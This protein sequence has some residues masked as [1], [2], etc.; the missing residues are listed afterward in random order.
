MTDANYAGT[1]SGTFTIGKATASVTFGNLTQ[2]F[3]GGALSPTVTTT[4]VG[5]AFTLSGAPDT[6]AG[7]YPV[8]ATVTDPNYAGT[9][10]GTFTIV[11]PPPPPPPPAG[12]SIARIPDQSNK[13]GDQIDLQIV[14]VGAGVSAASVTS[15]TS[16]SADED[17]RGGLFTAAALPGGLRINKEE[18][19]IRGRVAGGTA[20]VYNVTVTFTLNG[21][22]V[23]QG[24]VWRITATA[25]R[26]GGKG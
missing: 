7:S 1:A 15:I 2:T 22:T 12:I 16:A 8:T 13:E 24:F 6:N 17:G 25:P 3:T 11:A 14:V 10:S 26:K 4:P 21:A 20:G 19:E 23:S 9:A 5:L 18:G